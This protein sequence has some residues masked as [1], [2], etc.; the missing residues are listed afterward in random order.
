MA[1]RLGKKIFLP[2]A[3]QTLSKKEKDTLCVVVFSLKVPYGYN[4]NHRS[5]IYIY[6]YI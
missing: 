3:T 6:I 5:H 2:L 4:S 1:T